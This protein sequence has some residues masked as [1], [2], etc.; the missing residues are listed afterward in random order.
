MAGRQ[1]LDQVLIANKAVK[2]YRRR[3]QEGIIFKVNFKKAY[4]DVNW[5]FVDKVLWKKVLALNGDRRRGVH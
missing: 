5:A 4:D 2:N 3:T 1:I